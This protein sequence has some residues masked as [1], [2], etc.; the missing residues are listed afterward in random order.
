MHR[1]PIVFLSAL[2]LASAIAVPAIAEPIRANPVHIAALEK[3]DPRR[4]VEFP[5]ILKAADI[6][7]YDEIFSVQESGNWMR[8]DHLIA[9]LDDKILLGHVMAQRFLHPTQ[10]RSKYKELKDWLA[11]YGDHPQAR[12]LYKLAVRRKP[13]NWHA[14]KRPSLGSLYG[15]DAISTQI[16]IPRKKQSRTKRRVANKIKR[17]LRWWTRKGWTKAVKKSLNSKQTKSLLSQAE[18]DQAQARL[19]ASYFVA[20]RDEWAYARASKAAKRS[21]QYLPEA[22]WTA[23]LSSWR[24]RKFDV[25]AE[26]FEAVAD[27]GLSS[28]WMVTAAAF[29]AARTNLVNRKPE[30]VSKYL[31]VAA[32]HPRTFYGLLARRI[33]G[34]TTTYDWAV[35]NL[36][37][38]A[39]KAL[40]DSKPG[41]RALALMQVGEFPTFRTRAS[42]PRRA[43]R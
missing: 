3:A 27:A 36:E 37:S 6:N 8:A 19:G 42:L 31:K 11:K 18:Y 26:H 30:K 32:A 35:P 10:Y 15:N 13:R 41:K 4:P 25:A 38:S 33:L 20:G 34:V 29:W 14:P 7:R 16:A 43:R 39:M 1:A 2:C 24:M 9:K 5:K 12:R 23:G 21:G 40:A 22:H 17:Q 28:S